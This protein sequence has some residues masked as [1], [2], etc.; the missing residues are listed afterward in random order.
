MTARLL[1]MTE[2]ET[3]VPQRADASYEDL[4]EHVRTPLQQHEDSAAALSEI[5]GEMSQMQQQLYAA[6]GGEHGPPDLQ[7][8][9]QEFFAALQAS[10]AGLANE[11]AA[12]AR[13]AAQH[14]RSA[15]ARPS[16][17]QEET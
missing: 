14:E 9:A 11:M 13:E 16:S 3:P 4:P 8:T 2:H 12:T 15:H 1:G 7:R 5:A 6:L 10:T 17:H